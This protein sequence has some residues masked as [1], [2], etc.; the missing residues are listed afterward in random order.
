MRIAILTSGIL[1]IPAVN[2]GA[3]ENHID[4]YLRY[5]NNNNLHDMTVFSIWDEKIAGHLALQSKVNHYKYID[6][7][8]LWARICK[9]IHERFQ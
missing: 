4:F 1:P 9:N 6:T 7:K 3:V 2:G 8:N 5:N